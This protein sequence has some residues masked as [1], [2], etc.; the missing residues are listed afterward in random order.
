LHTFFCEF[1]SRY[2]EK[3]GKRIW[4]EKT[5]S[6]GYCIEEF[7]KLFPK[8]RVIH[9]IRDGRDAVC[10]L[11]RRRRNSSFHSIS[12]WLYNVAAARRY[13]QMSYYMEIRYE[14][15]VGA[16]YEQLRKICAFLEIDYDAAMLS[17]RQ[18]N[19][20]W[21]SVI[22]KNVHPSWKHNPLHSAISTQSVGRYKNDMDFENQA[23]FWRVR[24][25]PFAKK[26]LNF[27]NGGT[28]ALMRALEY[29]DHVDVPS[30][31]NLD[32]H[33]LDALTRGFA[34]IRREL[35]YERRVWLPLTYISVSV[36]P[37]SN[38]RPR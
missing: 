2:L 10:S 9:L 36:L 34:R 38:E 37:G 27:R 22:H 31:K 19:S 15:L 26:R 29:V 7:M 4:G 13:S 1:F 20:Y 25:T 21:K 23:L 18:S 28:Q 32:K 30:F 14:D 33:I 6:N 24:L 3:R 12:H 11:V 35:L 5:G 16:P 17:D 8:A